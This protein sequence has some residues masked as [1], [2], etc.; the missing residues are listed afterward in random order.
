[1]AGSEGAG[2]VDD[3]KLSAGV[4]RSGAR[5]GHEE[6]L[7]NGGCSAGDGVG[8]V[9]GSVEVEEFAEDG[10]GAG[11]W[12]GGK[13][14]GVHLWDQ[15]IVEVVGGNEGRLFGGG[16]FG[17]LGR[18]SA[19]AGE[20][21]FVGMVAQLPE[22]N[23]HAEGSDE[24]QGKEDLL[25]ARDHGWRASVRVGSERHSSTAAAMDAATRAW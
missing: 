23:A 2:Q 3:G 18:G 15:G 10:A 25:V 17:G 14:Q 6:D 5:N 11:S 12:V 20:Q 19:L 9:G 1:M 4:G 24:E 8:R 7:I 21:A 13:R 22:L 16:D